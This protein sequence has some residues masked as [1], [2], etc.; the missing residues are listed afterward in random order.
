MNGP[1]NC[2]C[3]QAGRAAG[4]AA[5]PGPAL[6]ASTAHHTLPCVFEDS[7]RAFHR[8]NCVESDENHPLI[9]LYSYGRRLPLHSSR[10]L[11]GIVAGDSTG[12]VGEVSG[13]VEMW[14]I[15]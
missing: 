14:R 10:E 4:L 2:S 11:L 7:T 6:F 15:I 3:P 8:G 12:R 1:H 13:L 9:P 5:R